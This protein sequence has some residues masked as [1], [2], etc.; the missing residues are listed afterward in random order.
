MHL[1]THN[2]FL[3]PVDVPTSQ[4][5]NLFLKIMEFFRLFRAAG[6]LQEIQ[7][8]NYSCRAFAD[9]NIHLFRNLAPLSAAAWKVWDKVGH[10][11]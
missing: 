1:C 5:H 3:T 7:V 10:T 11:L 4:R 2:G 9:L 6:Q 8:L